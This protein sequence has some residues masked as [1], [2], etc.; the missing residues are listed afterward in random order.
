MRV[1][2]SVCYNSSISVGLH[3][4]RAYCNGVFI[5]KTMEN[6]EIW[7]DVLWYEGEYE[8]SSIGRVKSLNY[9]REWITKILIPIKTKIWYLQITLH[10]NKVQKIKKIHRL[11]AEV[12]ISNPE[13]KLQINHKDWN[14]L[15]NNVENLEWCTCKENII[16]KFNILWYKSNFQT[17]HPCK[18]KFWENNRSSKKVYQYNPNW[19]LIR[20][21]GWVNE[22]ERQFWRLWISG[23]CLG[24]RKTAGGFIWK[25]NT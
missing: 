22:A 5:Y 13:N 16:H 12:F 20:I 15:N 17:N 3:A 1:I 8:V 24:K 7:K 2:K 23:C 21:W 11:V 14:K 9:H 19:I 10:K 4:N 6:L 25:Y 18:W